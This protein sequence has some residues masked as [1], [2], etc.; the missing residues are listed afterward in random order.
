MDFKSA[1]VILRVNS[2]PRRAPARRSLTFALAF[3]ERARASLDGPALETLAHIHTVLLC[4]PL[5]RGIF[6]ERLSIFLLTSEWRVAGG[7]NVMLFVEVDEFGVGQPRMDLDL[8]ARHGNVVG[9]RKD[10]FDLSPGEVRQADRSCFAAGDQF[11]HREPGRYEASFV[12]CS[13]GRGAI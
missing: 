6:D 4:D 1:M 12:T 8:V 2:I 11:F 3:A 9:V 10:F 7:E 5:H 13:M